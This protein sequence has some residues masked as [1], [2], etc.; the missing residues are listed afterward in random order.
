MKKLLISTLIAIAV[1][2][3]QQVKATPV[4]G[5][6]NIVH[7]GDSLTVHSRVFQKAEYARLGFR[8]AI[9]S[10]GGSRSMYDKMPK[11][12]FNGIDAVRHYKKISDKNTC[13]VIALGTNDSPSWKYEDVGG[14][15]VAVMRELKG[16]KVAWVTVWKGWKGKSNNSSAR[17]WNAMLEKKAEKYDNLYIIHWDKVIAKHTELL[18][19]DYVHYGATG[20]QMRAHYIARMVKDYWLWMD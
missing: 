7:I 15:V 9:I 17:N 2:S 4:D 12:D 19:P 8:K 20:S 14:R 16:M 6:S 13:W 1:I 10:A 18:N 5:C 11:D 3:P